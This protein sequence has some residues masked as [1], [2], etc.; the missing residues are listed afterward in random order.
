MPGP[1][2]PGLALVIAAFAEFIA[3]GSLGLFHR[4]RSDIHKRLMMRTAQE[5]MSNFR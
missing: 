5:I 2:L 4:H 3:L 1:A